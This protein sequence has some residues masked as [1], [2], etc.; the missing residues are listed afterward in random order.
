[1]NAKGGRMP[2]RD[3]TAREIIRELQLL[4]TV[5]QRVA[6]VFAGRHGLSSTDLEALLHVMQ[7][8]AEGA[9]L[10][11]GR[12]GEKLGVTSG[13][14]TGLI[15]RLERVGHVARRRDE[16]DR[17]RVLVHYGEA[18]ERVAREYFGPLKATSDEVMAEFD[19]RE[20]EV[21]ARFLAAMVPALAQHAEREA[22]KD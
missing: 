8:D 21:V 11:S 3:Q 13:A 20:L 7:A 18:A 16:R 15:D 9:P 1:M 22:A 14:A 6:Q 10:T 17:R 4:S 2:E 12:L 5:S 19:D